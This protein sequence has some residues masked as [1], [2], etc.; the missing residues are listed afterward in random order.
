MQE[1]TAAFGGTILNEKTYNIVLKHNF[2][3]FLQ[4]RAGLLLG[5]FFNAATNCRFRRYII[6]KKRTI[7]FRSMLSRLFLYVGAG[8]LLGEFF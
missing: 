3:V 1:R 7:S 4:I 8:S 5:E 6:E 2:M